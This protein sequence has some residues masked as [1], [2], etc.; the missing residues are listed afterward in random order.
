ML[1]E[2]DATELIV[3]DELGSDASRSLP[4]GGGENG[5]RTVAL[6]Q[7]AHYFRALGNKEIFATAIFLLFEL[8]DV[9]Q[10]IF[11]DHFQKSR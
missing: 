5:L 7:V 4:F 8:T 1:E 9:L 3:G 2:A 10:L 6:E 11:A